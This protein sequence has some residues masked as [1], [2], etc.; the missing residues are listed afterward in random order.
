MNKI[1]TIAGL[2][3]VL[4]GSVIINQNLRKENNRWKHNYEVLQDS[5]TVVETRYGEILYKNGSL[6]LEKKELENALDITTKQVRD[7]EKKLGSS[8]AYISKLEGRI[9]IKDTVVVTKVVH[10]TLTNSYYASY[11]DP[12]L[13]FDQAFTFPSTFKTYNIEMN[14]P[15]KVGLTDDYTIFVTSPCPYFNISN[16]EGAVINSSKFVSQKRWSIGV[17]AGFGLGYGL[18]NRQIDIGPQVGVGIGYKLL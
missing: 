10:D 9:K 18:V 2:L 17:Y 4:G 11:K 15:L 1:I 5:V 13:S 8:L 3:L 12:W 7:Y 16:I 6:I 14:I